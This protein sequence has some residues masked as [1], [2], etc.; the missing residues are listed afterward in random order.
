MRFCLFWLLM[1]L[2]GTLCAETVT[3]EPGTPVFAKPEF[4]PQIIALAETPVQLEKTGEK[5][6]LVKSHPLA[7]Y[8]HLAEVRLPDGRTGYTH[9]SIVMMPEGDLRFFGTMPAWRYLFSSLLGGALAALLAVLWKR[10]KEPDPWRWLQIGLVPVVLR[11]FLLSLLVNGAQN[12]IG[13]PADEPGYYGNLLSMMDWDF[14]ERWHFTVGTSFFYWPFELLFGN[15]DLTTLL[16]PLSWAEGFFFAPGCLFL[17]YL[18]GRKLLKS[19]VK[20]CA[21]M[22]IW[23]VIP[24]LWHNNPN[25]HLGVFSAYFAMPSASFDYQHY[26]NLIACGFSAMSDTPSTFLMLAV[27]ALILCARPCVFTIL[28]AAFLFGIGCMFRINNI[29]FLPAIGAMALLFQPWYRA[30]IKRFAACAAAGAAAFLIGFLPQLLANAHFFGSPLKFSYTNYE[31]GAHTYIAW[32]FVKMTAAF[33]GAT[34]QLIWIPGVLALLFFIRDRKLRTVLALWSIP[35]ILFFCG[36]SH[37]TDD[38]IRFVLTGYP[39]FFIAIAGIGLWDKPEGKE[40]LLPLLVLAGW[41]FCTPNWSMSDYSYYFTNPLLFLASRPSGLHPVCYLGIAL[42]ITGCILVF[43]R[44]R[45][46]GIFL[47]AASYLYIFGNA[48]LLCLLLAAALFRA[49]I[50]FLLEMR[51][52][53]NSKPIL[54]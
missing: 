6:V 35:I 2:F 40:R 16:V 9:N 24:F 17:A 52:I 22:L 27:M 54:K 5:L 1:L 49:I 46:L 37:G 11:M 19:D 36:Y 38:P 20:A 3:L 53:L 28:G 15:R 7:R 34:N 4:P 51:G 31:G 23:A 13:S 33:Y 21:A 48:Y 41:I 8:Y 47:A 12:I 26:I 29:L 30:G 14:T 32:I 18:I 10:R 43:R 45:R 42:V 44:N 50:D 25:F 39:A